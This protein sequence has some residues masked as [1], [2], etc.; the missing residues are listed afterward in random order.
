[1]EE[2][3]LLTTY[4]KLKRDIATYIPQDTDNKTILAINTRLHR[5]KD[6]CLNADTSFN[7]SEQIQDLHIAQKEL[8]HMLDDLLTLQQVGIISQTTYGVLAKS[9]ESCDEAVRE[10]SD[11]EYS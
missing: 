7:A 9:V 10:M 11:P 5:I 1:M 3:K 6:A 4:K 8:N 2:S